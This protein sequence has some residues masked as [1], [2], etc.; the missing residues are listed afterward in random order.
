MTNKSNFHYGAARC[1]ADALRVLCEDAAL[2]LRLRCNPRLAPRLEVSVR[3]DHAT[4]AVDD[5]RV[6]VAQQAD[7]AALHR[8]RRDMTDHETM[9]RA[10]EAAVGDQGNI[11]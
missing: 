1:R 4:L 6:A 7:A 5:D 11:V 10:A 2:D 3:F 9:R 8:F